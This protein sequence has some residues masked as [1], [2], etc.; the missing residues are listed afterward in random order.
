MIERDPLLLFNQ[1]FDRNKLKG[2]VIFDR[3]NT[4]IVDVP[5][6]RKVEDVSWLPGRLNCLEN[7]AS[8]GYE[9]AIATNQSA[10][11]FGKLSVPDYIQVTSNLVNQLNENNS[12][13]SMVAACPHEYEKTNRRAIC[14][15][16]KPRP[17]LLDVIISNSSILPRRVLF[18]GDSLS[19]KEAAISS[20]YEID[21]LYSSKEE[22]EFT[23]NILDWVESGAGS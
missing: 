2:L 6:L 22:M 10:I 18:V 23:Q 20:N 21:F 4:L 16:R 7:L 8:I 1:S 5:G 17:G 15:C 14:D 12:P 19:D 13:P 3:D 9:I 11:G